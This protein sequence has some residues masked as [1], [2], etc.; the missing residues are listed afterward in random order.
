MVLPAQ[1]IFPMFET[2]HGI[3]NTLLTPEPSRLRAQTMRLVFIGPPGVGK[4]TYAKLLVKKFGIPHIS[5]GDIF[6]EEIAQG[7]P[8][9]LKVKEYVEKGLLVPNEIVIEI[10]RRRLSRDDCKHGFILDGFPR[11][12]EQAKALERIVSIDAA[13]HFYAPREVVIERISGRLVCPKCG[14]IYH[15]KYRP[16]KKPG[17]CDVCGSELIRRTDD[18][19]EVARRRYEI[20]YQTMRPVIEYYRSKG[21]LIEVD[22]SRESAEAVVE[23]LEKTLRER[24]ILKGS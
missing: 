21:L 10:V 5:T 8:L 3:P 4:G 11:T 20:Y 1:R 9:G 23:E 17:I 18:S 24:G 7:T 6:R 2:L 15:A 13:V 19:P 12:I 16:P 22:A 14:A